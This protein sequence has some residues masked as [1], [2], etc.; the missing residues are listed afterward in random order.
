MPG[1]VLVYGVGN[2]TVEEA[3][4]NTSITTTSNYVLYSIACLLVYEV[5]TSLDDEVA[6]V[7]ALKWR[8]PKLLFIF[9]RYIIRAVLISLWIL[10]NYLGTSSEFC[11]IYSY[12]QM[13]PLRLA[14]LAAQ[15]LVVIRVWAIY[16]NSW[17]IFWVRA[18]LY[19][20]EVVGVTLCVVVATLDTE[21]AVQP[22]PLGCGLVSRSG[23]L[24]SRYA[25][26]IWFAPI[27]FEF[28][29]IVL[30]VAKLFP[31]WEWGGKGRLLGSAGN[32][33]VDVLARDSL[34]YFGFIFTCTLITAIMDAFTFSHPYHSIL[35]GPMAA[36]SCIAVSRMMINIGT[37]LDKLTSAGAMSDLLFAEHT[38]H[39]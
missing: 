24:L 9:N 26:A 35:L 12:L 20:F 1:P 18:I 10:E 36:V 3:I 21:A 6:R 37:P 2:Y 14:I 32:P 23:N 25:T 5:F 39:E 11:G 19:T 28:I 33:T 31:Q 8:L 15:A 30:T 27:C 17:L 4:Q 22:A 38:P 13:I 29:I 34:I 7:W 16:N